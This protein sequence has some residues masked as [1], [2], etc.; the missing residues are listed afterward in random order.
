M[1]PNAAAISQCAARS[2]FENRRIS[3]ISAI[4]VDQL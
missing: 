1:I 4:V 3:A 2:V